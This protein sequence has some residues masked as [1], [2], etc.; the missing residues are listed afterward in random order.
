MRTRS[1]STLSSTVDGRRYAPA[2]GL[3]GLAQSLTAEAQ[4]LA[5][6]AAA[7]PRIDRGAARPRGPPPGRPCTR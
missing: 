7:R 6:N 4:Q 5:D 1:L 2:S 3:S